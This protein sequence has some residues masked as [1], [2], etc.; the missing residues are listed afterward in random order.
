MGLLLLSG[1]FSRCGKQGL[2]SGYGLRLLSV[3][4]SL[5]GEHGLSSLQLSGV[6]VH[7]HVGSSHTRDQTCV[8]CTGRW[9][10]THCTSKEVLV[11]LFLNFWNLRS[12]R[13]CLFFFFFF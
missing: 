10:L 12:M 7:G 11:Y 2:L 13:L 8:P 1:L 5:V 6:L 4:A 9:I 3:V